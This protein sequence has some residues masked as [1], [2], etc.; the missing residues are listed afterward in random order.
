MFR[1]LFT[2]NTLSE[3]DMEGLKARGIEITTGRADYSENELVEALKGFDGYI[4]GGD[5]IATKKVIDSTTGLKIIAFLGTGYER[6]VDVAAAAARGI[7]VTNTPRANAYTTAEFTV[8]LMLNAVKK[9]TYMNNHTK[10]GD[11]QKIELWN[12]RGRT[13]GIIGLGTVGTYVARILRNGF[14]VEIVYVSRTS[15]TEIEAELGARRVELPTLLRGSDIVSLH[16]LYSNETIGLLGSSEL[17]LMK[18]DAILVNAARA[19]LVD[20]HA[21]F[22][23]LESGRISIAAFDGYYT[24][25]VPSPEQDTYG[26]LNLPDNRFIVTPHTAYNSKDAIKDMERMVLDNVIA[27]FEDREPP[28]VVNPDYLSRK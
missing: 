16:A 22:Q 26:L 11:W 28:N 18:P 20:G 10:K 14:G 21:L 5:E 27:A 19:E 1:V 25:P 6:F 15:K 2:G 12:L 17:A 7:P 9:L 4:L 8:A 13:V 3:R 24:E 23:A